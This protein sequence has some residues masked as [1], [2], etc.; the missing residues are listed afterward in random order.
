MEERA[1]WSGAAVLALGLAF[2]LVSA[3]LWASG[4]R[5]HKLLRA[6]LR[7]GGLLL[8]L[9]AVAAGCFDKHDSAMVMCYDGGWDSDSYAEPDIDVDS[10]TLD[11]GVTEI[12]Y[13]KSLTLTITNT[14][15]LALDISGFTLDDDAGVFGFTDPGP[16]TLATGEA[17]AI[18]VVFTPSGSGDYEGSLGIASNDPDHPTLQVLLQGWGITD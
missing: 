12:G 1:W 5:S 3:L 4:G 2:A 13:D 11:F 17:L 16:V 6:K 9:G 8:S 14:G 15:S 10:T 18:E 7:L